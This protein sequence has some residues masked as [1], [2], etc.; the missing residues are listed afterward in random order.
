MKVNLAYLIYLFGLGMITIG[1]YL[2]APA[3]ALIVAGGATLAFGWMLDR[4]TE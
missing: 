4:E 1:A 3:Y 2:L